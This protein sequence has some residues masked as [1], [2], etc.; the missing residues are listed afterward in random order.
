MTGRVSYDYSGKLCI[1]TG[2]GGGIGRETAA[3]FAAAGASLGLIDLNRD[4]LVET[5]QAMQELGARTIAVA[6]DTTDQAAVV[7]AHARIKATL[8]ACDVL[9][10]NAGI[11]AAGALETLDLAAWNKVLAVNLTAYF[12]CAQAFGRD[13]LERGSGS[14]VH[15]ASIAGSQPQPWSGSYSVAKIG[16]TMLS[17][18]LAYE[19]GPRGVRSNSLSPGLVR[20]PMSEAFYQAGDV[21]QRRADLVPLRRVA[22]PPDMANV[23][24]WLGSEGAA[25][26]TGQD[27]VVDGGLGQIVMGTVPRPGFTANQA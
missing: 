18:Q 14:L 8:G 2:A 25:Y 7:A 24:A 9:V 23:A 22:S 12:I 17:R 20:T 26:V 10:N 27:I 19:W 11:L 1:V 21:A 4:T 16:V 3:A 13:M 5:E 6:C 15:V